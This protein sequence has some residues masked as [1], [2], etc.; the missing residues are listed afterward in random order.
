M[1]VGLVTAGN[2][3]A[4]RWLVISHATTVQSKNLVEEVHPTKAGPASEKLNTVSV[5]AML[6][7][8]QCTAPVRHAANLA[9][10]K[11]LG[12]AE[13]AVLGMTLVDCQ[14]QWIPRRQEPQA[15]LGR[16]LPRGR[17]KRACQPRRLHGGESPRHRRLLCGRGRARAGG[18]AGAASAARNPK[19]L[20][21]KC[22]K[23][24][25]VDA[26]PAPKTTAPTPTAPKRKN[27]EVHHN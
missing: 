21:R 1:V 8:D 17:D 7:A 9:H 11:G 3:H 26:A 12:P 10:L 20:F 18:Q 27:Q 14:R 13:Q 4:A 19:K 6:P 5:L 23:T 16:T 15:G 2:G 24:D 25:C 22:R